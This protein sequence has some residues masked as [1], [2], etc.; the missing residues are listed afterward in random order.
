MAPQDQRFCHVPATL[1]ETSFTRP[2]VS[3]ARLLPAPLL[4]SDPVDPKN[5]QTPGAP[6]HAPRP[7]SFARP[8]RHPSNNFTPA[9]S[10]ARAKE[11]DRYPYNRKVA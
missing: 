4:P 7:R 6:C 1:P 11:P 10:P 5:R 9:S 3:Q 2:G 8:W